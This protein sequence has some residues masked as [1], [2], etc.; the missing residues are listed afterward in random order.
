MQ[1]DTDRSTTSTC[2]DS[3][4]QRSPSPARPTSTTSQEVAQRSRWHTVLLEAGGLSAALS[5]ESLRR[6]RY[7]LSWLLAATEHLDAQ[8]VL[9]RDFTLQVDVAKVRRDIVQTVRGA[10]DVVAKYAG[11]GALGEGGRQRVRGFVLELPRRWATAMG[12]TQGPV[13]ERESVSAAGGRAR[14]RTGHHT[15]NRERGVSAGMESPLAS[16]RIHPTKPQADEAAQRVLTLAT[17]SLD[18][19]RGVMSVVKDSLDRADAWVERLGLQRDGVEVADEP[20][21][22]EMR[23]EGSVLPP[24]LS[25]TRTVSAQ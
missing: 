10:V 5:E 21:E 18:M 23:E 22:A 16:P 19:M 14:R 8:I 9:L 12:D 17:E 24:S 13:V 20:A 3:P 2:V 6:L 4:R 15:H 1:V 25:S 11:G 7:V